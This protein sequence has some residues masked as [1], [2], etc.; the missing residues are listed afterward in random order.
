[1]KALTVACWMDIPET[2]K[3]CRQELLDK[4]IM[5]CAEGMAVV[6][7]GKVMS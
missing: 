5:Q 1:M 6:Y 3:V 2:L 7:V 4:D